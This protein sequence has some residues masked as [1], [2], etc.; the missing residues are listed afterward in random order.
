MGATNIHYEFP[1]VD[2]GGREVSARDAYNQLV[3]EALEYH[4]SDPYSGTIATCELRGKI[5]APKDDEEY[6]DLLDRVGKRQ[7][8]YY[9]DEDAERWVFIGWAA[10]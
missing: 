5:R 1:L 8:R 9:K 6:D 3:D 2:A 10:C 7:V 4:G